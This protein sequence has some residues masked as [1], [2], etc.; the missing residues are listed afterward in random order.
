MTV[1]VEIEISKTTAVVN[2]GHQICQNGFQKSYIFTKNI[3]FVGKMDKKQL[4]IKLNNCRNEIIYIDE[5]I[6]SFKKR[7]LELQNEIQVLESQ[8]QENDAT[9]NDGDKFLDEFSWSEKAQYLLNNVFKL[10]EFRSHQLPTINATLSGY[11]VLLI[12]PTGG[13]KSLCFQ[14]PALISKGLI[15]LIIF[16]QILKVVFRFNS[17]YFTFDFINGRSIEWIER[18]RYP[19]RSI[20]CWNGKSRHY[21]HI[22]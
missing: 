12:L 16:D 4:N 22:E 6:N 9:A 5:Q 8:L 19:N 11:D 3:N 17:G 2:N 14:L 7:R 21:T 15:E 1:C 13:G 20:K 18:N 10:R